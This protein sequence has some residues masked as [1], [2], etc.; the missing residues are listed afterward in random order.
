MYDY[1]C[2][3]NYGSDKTKYTTTVDRGFVKFPS[4]TNVYH[5][6]HDCRENVYFTYTAL[7]LVRLKT[8]ASKV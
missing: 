7:N 4:E 5:Y 1:H 8:H 3:K 2:P 6:F